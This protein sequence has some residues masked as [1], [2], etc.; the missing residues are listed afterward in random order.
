MRLIA[1]PSEIRVG[2]SVTFTVAMQGDVTAE[3]QVIVLP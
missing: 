2:E 3:V 1:T